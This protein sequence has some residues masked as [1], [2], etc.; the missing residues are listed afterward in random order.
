M[1]ITNNLIE[2][3]NTDFTIFTYNLNYYKAKKVNVRST[4]KKAIL[5]F[6]SECVNSN[7]IK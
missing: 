5:L 7:F 3:V 2:Y 4:L 1:V 6:Y